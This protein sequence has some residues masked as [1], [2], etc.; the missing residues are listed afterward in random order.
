MISLYNTG[1][2]RQLS[3]KI[4]LVNKYHFVQGGADRAYLDMADIL[5]RAGHEIAFF[6]MRHSKNISTPWERYF[7]PNVE[8]G[9][10]DRL[11]F[12]EKIR[13]AKNILWNREA[14]DRMERI[15]EEFRPN[16]VHLHNIYHQLSPSILRPIKKRGIPA[17]MTLHDYKLISPNYNLF[18][19]GNIWEE[20]KNG[21]YWK[22]V[23][24]RCVKD[25]FVKSAICATE[26][27]IHRWIGA[28]ASV[29]LF[30]SPSRFLIKKFREFGFDRPIEFLSNPL[31]PF[32]EKRLSHDLLEN[33][34]FVFIGRLSPE[35][36]V[37][38]ILIALKKLDDASML[39]IVGDGP[40][41][42][43]LMALAEDLGISRR[44]SFPG[45]LSGDALV[46]ERS[47]ALAILLPSL[48][49]EN[50]PYA[51]TE[52]LAEGAIVIAARRGGIPERIRDGE[53]GFLFD[54]DDVN[55]LVEKMR[56][57]RSFDNDSL[58]RIRV[59]ACESVEDL[60]EEAYMHHLDAFYRRVIDR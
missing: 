35:K 49:Y 16:I 50:M 30:L 1:I 55:S 15:L 4:L 39:H 40:E 53:N 47:G 37:E 28:Y 33:A 42:G 5:M 56:L 6:S 59:A 3:M 26:A 60:R 19:H 31:V 43:R 29:K 54:S 48:W 10:M 7:V 52:A 23:R 11:G 58:S 41:R 25:S 17:V 36:G 8:Y 13:V 27:Y 32:P 44:V 12:S 45:Y 57:V 18:V 9:D 22:C 38:K 24:D 14:E 34:S 2:F 20:T 21:A 46:R 51:L